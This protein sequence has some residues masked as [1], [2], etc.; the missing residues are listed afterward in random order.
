[1][2]QGNRAYD[3]EKCMGSCKEMFSQILW[4][5]PKFSSS[6]EITNSAG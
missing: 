6:K 3:V 5:Y 4:L 2:T 1:M